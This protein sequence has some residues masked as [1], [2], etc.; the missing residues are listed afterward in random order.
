MIRREP[1]FNSFAFESFRLDVLDVEIC[2]SA[3]KQKVVG[4]I[5]D[6]PS[7]EHILK[8]VVFSFEECGNTSVLDEQSGDSAF[9][10]IG[11][12]I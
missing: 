7:S 5:P 6:L 3:S 9:Y 11:F 1:T 2:T 10:G 8:R 4:S 12:V